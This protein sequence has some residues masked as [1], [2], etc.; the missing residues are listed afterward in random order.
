MQL[1]YPTAKRY[2]VRQPQQ[3]LSPE[4]NIQA[5]SEFLNRLISDFG[6]VE[7]A[8]AAY[9]AGPGIVREWQRRYPTG[10]INL[11]VEMIPYSETR[12]YVRL[13]TRNYKI[14]QSILLKTQ[15]DNSGLNQQNLN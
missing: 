2:G 7:L 10:N 13:V 4:V 1:I 15:S 11:F 5:G 6:S 12:E 9:N 8:L 14:Y 3:L